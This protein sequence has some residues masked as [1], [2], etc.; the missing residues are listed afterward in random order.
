MSLSNNR[1]FYFILFATTEETTAA[2]LIS[3]LGN[4][5]REFTH[6]L[7]TP[8]ADLGSG[9]EGHHFPFVFF[10]YIC[11]NSRI[12]REFCWEALGK[13]SSWAAKVGRLR[14][15][16]SPHLLP[17]T[18]HRPAPRPHLLMH[19]HPQT[20]QPHWHSSATAI[21]FIQIG[22]SYGVS[23]LRIGDGGS[24]AKLT[25]PASSF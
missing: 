14:P 5:T 11:N 17:H 21:V 2:Q 9:G 25:Y 1:Y 10:V 6:Y 18:D 15:C 12:S 8:P 19:R 7:K 24:M 16:V 23:G 20:H 13:G 22:V 4:T 3:S